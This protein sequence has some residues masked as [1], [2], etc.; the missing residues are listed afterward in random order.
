MKLVPIV[1]EQETM[2]PA[3]PQMTEIASGLPYE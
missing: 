1:S 2:V 3:T